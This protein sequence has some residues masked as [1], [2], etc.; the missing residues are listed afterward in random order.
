MLSSFDNTNVRVEF[1]PWLRYP[2][3]ISSADLALPK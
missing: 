3:E 2:H 1:F